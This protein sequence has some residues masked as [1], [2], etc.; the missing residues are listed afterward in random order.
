MITPHINNDKP[1][2]DQNATVV[3]SFISFS[4]ENSLCTKYFWKPASVKISAKLM[5]ITAVVNT[6]KAS[7]VNRRAKT[8]VEIGEISF[9]TISVIVDHLVAANTLE[10]KFDISLYPIK[11]LPNLVF[12]VNFVN[13]IETINVIT[14][15]TH[16]N[17]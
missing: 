14:H 5:T 12:K 4:E 15:P 7:G 1:K 13:K 9:A 17:Q 6:P 10:F 3:D 8:I 11:N 2:F 16:G